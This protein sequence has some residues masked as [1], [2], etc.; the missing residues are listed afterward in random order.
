MFVPNLTLPVFCCLL[1]RVSSGILTIASTK[2]L[3]VDDSKAKN[4]IHL[5]CSKE[6]HAS[7]PSIPTLK[8]TFSNIIGLKEKTE[9]TYK[10]TL[11]H[12]RILLF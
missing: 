8:R 1:G 4:I 9:K 7:L 2:A 3:K 6:I 11:Y 5:N 12:K 10:E